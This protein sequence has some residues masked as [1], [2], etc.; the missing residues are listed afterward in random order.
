MRKPGK[1]I[2]A[3]WHAANPMPERAKADQ[4]ID[5]HLRHAAECG[6]KPIPRPVFELMAVRGMV[7]EP[8]RRD[9]V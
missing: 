4:K 1:P 2:N 9:A 3:A 6:C 8:K 5:W 7:P